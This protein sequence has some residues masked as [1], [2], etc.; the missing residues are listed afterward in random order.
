MTRLRAIRHARAKINVFPG[1][2]TETPAAI[3][4][5]QRLRLQLDEMQ[6]NE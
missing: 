5:A 1:D 2:S 3:N 4:T 6:S